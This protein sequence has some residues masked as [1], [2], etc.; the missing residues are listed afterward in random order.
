MIDKNR[1]L[2]FKY[3]YA[4]VFLS[5]MG[6]AFFAYFTMNQQI[7][8]QKIY[9]KIINLSGKQ[10]MLSQKT[11]L[12]VARIYRS[13]EVQMHSHL[14]GLILLMKQEHQFIVEHLTSSHMRAIYFEPPYELDS[15]VTAYFRLLENIPVE[16]TLSYVEEIEKHSFNLL[17][18]LNHAVYEFEK[19]AEMTTQSLKNQEL[20]IL[21]GTILTLILESLLIVVPAFRQIEHREKELMDAKRFAMQ[22]SRHK[23]QFLANMS[24][25]IRTPMNAILGFVE[26]LIKTERSEERLN[27]LKVV[28]NSGKTLLS[29][30]NDILDLSKIE[31]GKMSLESHPCNPVTI[32]TESGM[33]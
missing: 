2:N 16:N 14:D 30:I 9:A 5:L 13:D 18:D 3:I 28:K 29:I 22:E 21:I 4:V 6:W 27:Q 19:E 12:M 15:K 31:S 33:L 26:Q 24:H 10:R 25:E 23:S 32:F 20:F 17:P 7:E 1:L 11:A 8:S